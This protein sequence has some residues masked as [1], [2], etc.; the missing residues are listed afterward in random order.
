[1][2]DPRQ[3]DLLLGALAGQMRVNAAVYDEDPSLL[4]LVCTD[5]D[6]AALVDFCR[7]PVRAA[8]VRLPPLVRPGKQGDLQLALKYLR[9]GGPRELGRRVAARLRRRKRL[10]T[11]GVR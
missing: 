11:G 8:D 9:Q 7:R 3:R 6:G 1:A 4:S 5:P 2:A 10:T